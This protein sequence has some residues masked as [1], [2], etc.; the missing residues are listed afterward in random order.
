[1]QQTTIMYIMLP[2]NRGMSDIP[3]NAAFH[4]TDFSLLAAIYFLRDVMI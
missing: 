2:R 4:K 1:M 3:Q